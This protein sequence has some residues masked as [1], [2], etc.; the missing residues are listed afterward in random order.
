[1]A[2]PADLPAEKLAVQTRGKLEQVAGQLEQYL[3]QQPAG[4]YGRQVVNRFPLMLQTACNFTRVG[5]EGRQAVLNCYLPV[6]AGHNLLLGAELA[7]AETG[8][9]TGGTPLAAS[10]A[11]VDDAAG[12][13]AAALARKMS[14]SFPRD[15]LEHCFELMSAELNIPI[16]ILGNDL[17]LEGI[18]K[19][20]SFALDERDKP[21]G[22]I[23]SKVLALANP[24]GKLVY[25]VKPG[26]SGRETIF[27]TTRAAAAKRNERVAG[28]PSKN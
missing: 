22:E 7:L 27:I 3:A 2:S 20:Q 13:V 9:P 14:L 16:V 23:L 25:V 4:A 1:M 17:Q 12:D 10:E 19:N 11:P 8:Q 6:S 15:T 28:D 26:D 18:T 21:A 5:A 24:D